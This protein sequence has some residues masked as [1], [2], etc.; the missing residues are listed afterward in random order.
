MSTRWGLAA[1]LLALPATPR[2]GMAQS[3]RTVTLTRQAHGEEDLRVDVRFAE[4]RLHLVAGSPSALYRARLAYDEDRATH[5]TT[6]DSRRR[7]LRLEVTKVRG[8]DGNGKRHELDL[9]LSPNVPTRLDFT[10]GAA[11]AQLDLGGLAISRMDLSTGA[12]EST[13]DFSQPNRVACDRLSLKAGAAEIQ[14]LRLG[15][16]RCRRI[17]VAGAAGAFTLDFTGAWEAGAETRVSVKMGI[18]E[19]T[20]RLPASLG[21]AVDLTRLFVGFD[22]EGFT[23][24]GGRYYSANYD[25]AAATL[26]V[27][28]DAALGDIMVE[29]VP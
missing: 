17:E 19:M 5:V 6:Y 11:N 28:I 1:L 16:A 2:D 4:G 15:N 18:G 13:V 12:S 27:D 26:F 14:L 29:W 20:L 24:R 21:V 8:G 25:T 10:F 22:R 3:F 23:R 7:Q 9:A